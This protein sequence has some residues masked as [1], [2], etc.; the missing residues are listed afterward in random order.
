V[1]GKSTTNL[2]TCLYELNTPNGRSELNELRRWRDPHLAYPDDQKN[3]GPVDTEKNPLGASGEWRNWLKGVI[4]SDTEGNRAPAAIIEAARRSGKNSLRLRVVGLATRKDK[5]VEC[6]ERSFSI[7]TQFLTAEG[8]G[9]FA[10]RTTNLNNAVAKILDP[11]TKAW[12]KAVGK[13][14]DASL[15]KSLAAHDGQKL[16]PLR[17]SLAD[18]LPALELA[19][20]TTVKQDLA[21]SN[22]AVPPTR[23]TIGWD[24]VLDAAVLSTTFGSPLRRREATERARQALTVEIAKLGKTDQKEPEPENKKKPKSPK[25]DGA[26][27]TQTEQFIRRLESLKEGERSRLRRLAGKPLDEKLEGFDLFTGLWWTLR[28]KSAGAPRRETSWMI[29]K[30][31][32]AFPMRHVRPADPVARPTLPRV[33]GTC[34]PRDEHGRPRFRTRFDSLLCS[35]L[36]ALEPHLCWALSVVAEA[37]EKGKCSGLDWVELLDNLSIWDRGEE[38]RR[39]RDVRDIWAEQYLETVHQSERSVNHAD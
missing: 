17:S 16:H 4:Q 10:D 38:H 26:G 35:P 13:L 19:M 32:G 7:P 25:E 9:K 1:C 6:W 28:D 24:A 22:G 39:E 11:Q 29:A 18:S 15:L 20:F 5:S 34:E 8:G 14:R 23:P 37:V 21:H 36:A 33:L 27:S 12:T 2:V 30:L 31:Y 3:L